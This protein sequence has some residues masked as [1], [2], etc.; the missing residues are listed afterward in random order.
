MTAEIWN[1]EVRYTVRDRIE[2]V[3]VSIVMEKIVVSNVV[4]P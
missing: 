2:R 3:Y 1:A 4:M